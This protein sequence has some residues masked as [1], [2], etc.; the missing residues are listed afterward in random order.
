MPPALVCQPSEQRSWCW[1]DIC[2]QTMSF[3]TSCGAR[4]ISALWPAEA[5]QHHAGD[6]WQGTRHPFRRALATLA[7][8]QIGVQDQQLSCWPE[9]SLTVW[10][11][12]GQLK[13]ATT[14]LRPSR[15]AQDARSGSTGD[16]CPHLRCS[17]PVVEIS[18]RGVPHNLGEICQKDSSPA[19]TRDTSLAPP[20]A[21]PRTGGH[22][23]AA[24]GRP[25][26]A[27][28]CTPRPGRPA[29]ISL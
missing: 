16:I 26:A 11:H 20:R 28:R 24:S 15:R 2:S 12:C 3:H 7:N 14:M 29:G 4:Q 23:A 17:R 22:K 5:C 13:P 25:A 8:I 9:A 6:Q 27:W 1:E 10:P 19:D 21:R 18:A